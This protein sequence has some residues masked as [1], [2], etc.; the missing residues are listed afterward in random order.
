[1]EDNKQEIGKQKG[2]TV[3]I[4]GRERNVEH[5]QLSYEGIVDIAYPDGIQFEQPGF[6][7]VFS[8]GIARQEEGDLE[9][10]QYLKLQDGMVI[11]VTPYDLS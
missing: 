6:R 8:G 5:D 3:K 9:E 7:I 4:N 1:M 2:F 11:N 10:G